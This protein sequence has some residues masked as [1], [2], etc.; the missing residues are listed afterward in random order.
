[1]QLIY[2]TSDLSEAQRLSSALTSAGVHNSVSGANSAQ[3]SSSEASGTPGSVG[4]WLTSA[5]ELSRAREVMVATGFLAATHTAAKPAAWLGSVW[6]KLALAAIVAV[7][8][9]LVAH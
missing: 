4:V 9:A 8:V 1:M 2:S 7:V 5:S 3:L 6:A